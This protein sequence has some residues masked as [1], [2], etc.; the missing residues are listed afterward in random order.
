M[1]ILLRQ[2][3]KVNEEN[4]KN[5]ELISIIKEVKYVEILDTGVEFLIGE[6]HHFMEKVPFGLTHY[7]INPFNDLDYSF[8]FIQEDR[9]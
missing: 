5:E 6:E 9:E 7:W 2:S 3:C 8:M 4:L 1:R